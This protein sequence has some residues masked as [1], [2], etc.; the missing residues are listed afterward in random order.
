MILKGELTCVQIYVVLP[1]ARIVLI[2]LST[3]KADW[4]AH[5]TTKATNT[6]E[7]AVGRRSSG[8]VEV[9]STQG[10]FP[11]IPARKVTDGLPPENG[12]YVTLPYMA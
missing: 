9:E 1:T 4:N 11:T 10:A 2:C 7:R 3:S 12:V 8:S 5:D 6:T